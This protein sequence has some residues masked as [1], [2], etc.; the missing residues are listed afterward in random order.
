MRHEV[1]GDPF[2]VKAHQRLRRHSPAAQIDD[3]IASIRAVEAVKP[4]RH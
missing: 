2:G 1:E 4:R 3:E